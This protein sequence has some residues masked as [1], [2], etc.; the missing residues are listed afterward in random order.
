MICGAFGQVYLTR[1]RFQ[2]QQNFSGHRSCESTSPSKYPSAKIDFNSTMPGILS[3]L[4]P[5]ADSSL[6]FSTT[7][8][9]ILARRIGEIHAHGCGKQSK[10][11]NETDNQKTMSDPASLPGVVFSNFRL[12]SILDRRQAMVPGYVGAKIRAEGD[13]V[14]Y[15]YR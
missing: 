15:K 6:F 4:S 3:S 12:P 5:L 8:P 1:Q 9:C 11:R 14:L 10:L 2:M 7:L 13:S